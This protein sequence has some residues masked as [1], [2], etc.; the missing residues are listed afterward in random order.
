MKKKQYIKPIIT[1]IVLDFTI[2]LQMNSGP[3]DPPPHG[4]GSKG[5]KT[6]PFQSPF[7]NKPF[8]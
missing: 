3:I 1:K 4:G 6:D 5:N 2:S 7:G 8:G